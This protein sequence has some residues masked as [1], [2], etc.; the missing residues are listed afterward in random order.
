MKKEDLIKTIKD[1]ARDLDARAEDI[2][3]DF[4][5]RI[6][7]IEITACIEPECISEWEVTK[8]YPVIPINIME[9]IVNNPID[10]PKTMKAQAEIIAPIKTNIADEIGKAIKDSLNPLDIKIGIDYGDG[11]SKS[12]MYGGDG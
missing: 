12:S 4:N 9:D 10:A 3:S 2:A 8:Y 11:Y 5:K 7:K 1:L 6:R